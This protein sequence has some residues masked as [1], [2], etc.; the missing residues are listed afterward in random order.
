MAKRSCIR[1][2]YSFAMKLGGPR[3]C[4]TAWH[5][6]SG[7]FAGGADV[8][9][10]PGVL[11]WPLPADVKIQPTLARGPVRIP[12]RLL[13]R[14]RSYAVHDHIVSRRLE[15]LAGKIDII[16]TWP[17]GSRRT[18]EVASRLGIPTVIERPN[19]YT[20]FAFEVVRRECQRLGITM[21]AGHEHAYDAEVLRIEEEEYRLA[22]R[23]LCPSDFVARTFLEHGFPNE[24]LARHQYGFDDRLYYPPTTR[25]AKPGI[26]MLFAGGCTP[27]KGL[28]YA[29]QAWLQ[30]EAHHDGIFLIAGEFIPGYAE[31]LSPMLSDPSIQV[32]GHRTDIPELMRN[33]DV[34]DSTQH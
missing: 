10:F 14:L 2:L 15:A 21:P 31:K 18:L 26:R 20:R 12:Y 25:D 28:H 6:V 33:S 17:L 16:H 29:L 7:L 24:K 3:I 30:S 11:L 5:Q 32:L 27:R 13:G 8:L 34:P 19:A 4:A 9:V 23:L 22:D 1:V